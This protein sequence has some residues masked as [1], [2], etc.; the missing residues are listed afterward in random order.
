MNLIPMSDNNIFI[1]N[2]NL[3][4][5][6]ITLKALAHFNK[7]CLYII[8]YFGPHSFNSLASERSVVSLPWAFRPH[9]YQ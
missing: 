8:L 1:F 5:L 2:D 9:I 6:F 3:D 7:Y 4:S